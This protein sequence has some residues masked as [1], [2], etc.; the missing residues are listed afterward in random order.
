[1]SYQ[2]IT[3]KQ[4]PSAMIDA[5]TFATKEFPTNELKDGEY[6]VKVTHLSLDPAMRGWVSPDKN[7]YI[8]PV[9]IDEIMRSLGFGIVCESKNDNYPV[10][11]QVAGMTGWTEQCVIN[12]DSLSIVPPTVDAKTALSTLGM[13][14]LTAYI[15]YNDVLQAPAKH[16]VKP[17]TIV[18]TGAAG[19]V[20]SV[21]VQMAKAD[22][23]TVIA[24]AG[25][26]EKCQWLKDDLGA[27]HVIN[28]KTDD[29]AARITAASPQGI[30]LFFENTGGA[31]QHTVIERINEH[32]KVAVCGLIADYHQATPTPAP[33]WINL[34]KRRASI[35]GFTITDHFHRAPELVQGVMKYLLAGKIQNRTHVI[36]GLESAKLGVNMLYSGENT[37]KL[38]VEL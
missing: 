21:V 19:A 20:G 13:P 36:N 6:R 11:T 32:G 25:S 2:A 27:D 16:Q 17:Q 23:L 22:G 7:S 15:G 8:P 31:A 1:M 9:E 33:S 10:G 4:Y 3:L 34:I 18:V 5:D 14:G 30:D 24:L 28:Y 35:E 29:V 37:G 38:I 12:D 26:D